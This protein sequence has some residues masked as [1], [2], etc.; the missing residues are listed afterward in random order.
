MA[1]LVEYFKRFG[2]LYTNRKVR[3]ENIVDDRD[4]LNHFYQEG[5][6]TYLIMD[7]YTNMLLGFVMVN[8]NT[9]VINGGHRLS[10]I[11]ILPQ[12]RR[13]FLGYRVCQEVFKM[14]QGLWEIEPTYDDPN[15]YNFFKRVIEDYTNRFCDYKQNTFVFKKTM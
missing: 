10:E 5:R 15:S 13:Q 9:R 8:R 12:F 11:V 7:P 3:D 6:D 1:K 4:Y 2:N 14:Y